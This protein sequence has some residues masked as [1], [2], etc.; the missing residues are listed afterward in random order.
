MT[1]KNINI[2]L[3]N[4]TYKFSHFTHKSITKYISRKYIISYF[5][6]LENIFIIRKY[7][8]TIW[9]YDIELLKS[10]LKHNLMR[11]ISAM[12][13]NFMYVN[14]DEDNIFLIL[15]AL[16]EARIL[17]CGKRCGARI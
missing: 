8:F 10:F 11:H 5:Q 3:N 13:Q 1:H 7:C 4:L 12:I 14:L 2:A 15:H 6:P 17:I 9:I 16:T